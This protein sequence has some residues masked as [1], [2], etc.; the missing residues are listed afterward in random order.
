M[1]NQLLLTKLRV[2]P[3]LKC[4]QYRLSGRNK[5]ANLGGYTFLLTLRNLCDSL[6]TAAS[7]STFISWTLRTEST[8]ELSRSE[9]MLPY[10]ELETIHNL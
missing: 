5:P 4:S 8:T 3:N 9:A 6:S 10:G 7:I 1:S 2:L